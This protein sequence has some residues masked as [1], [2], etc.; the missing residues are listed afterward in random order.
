MKEMDELIEVSNI[1]MGPNGCP[2][3]IEQTFKTLQPYFLEEVHE[4]IEAIDS[5]ESS[6][7]VEELGDLFYTVVFCAK[8]AEKE[9]H[10]TLENVITTLREKL[11]RRHPHVFSDLAIESIEELKVHWEKIKGEEKAH[12]NRES[13]LDGIPPT[14]P[15]IQKAQKMI[16]KISKRP[17]FTLAEK[18]QEDKERAFGKKLLDLIA[19]AEK[20]EIDAE[21][22]LRR[23]VKNLEVSFREFEKKTT[24]ADL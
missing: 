1:L 10:F 13:L 15:L 20:E 6:K 4:V 5:G 17:K 24:G 8:I 22:A 11:V 23:E 19:E 18:A 16:G 21:G 7:I 14:M 3:D 9:G 12:E 2:W